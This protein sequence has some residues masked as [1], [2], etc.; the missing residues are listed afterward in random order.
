MNLLLEEQDVACDAK[1]YGMLP[2]MLNV[3][4]QSQHYMAC[5]VSELRA[6]R[7]ILYRS[8]T[9]RMQ[10]RYCPGMDSPTPRYSDIALRAMEWPLQRLDTAMHCTC[11]A[12]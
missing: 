5:T 3:T 7:K 10:S 12:V 4:N 8:L 11:A 1:Q 2:H 6:P 9:L